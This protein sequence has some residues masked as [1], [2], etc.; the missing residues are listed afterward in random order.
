MPYVVSIDGT[1]VQV[2]ALEGTFD[3]RYSGGKSAYATTVAAAG[4]TTL[5]TPA[6]GNAIRVVW[7][8]AIPSPDNAG[9][10]RVRFKF[11]AAGA[12]FYEA[13]ALAHWEVFQG[14]VDVPL[15]LNLATNEPVSIT[16]HYRE[17]TP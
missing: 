11:G 7:V 8:A 12:P 1:L 4:D 2:P 14:A 9:A 10:N 6:S 17:V 13:Y 15:V 5:V 16:V 3:E